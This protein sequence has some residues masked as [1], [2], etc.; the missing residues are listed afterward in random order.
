VAPEA[1]RLLGKSGHR[2][3]LVGTRGEEALG[4]AEVIEDRA[5]PRRSHAAQLVEKRAERLVQAA[6]PVVA[7]GEAVS[8]VAQA[9]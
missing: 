5:T 7:D 6:L 2:G 1:R 3:Q 4:R 9:L 8:L